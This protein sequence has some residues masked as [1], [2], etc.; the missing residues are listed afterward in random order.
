[1]YGITLC[2]LMAGDLIF[3]IVLE[4]FVMDQNLFMNLIQILE[5]YGIL[6]IMKNYYR[7]ILEDI[8]PNDIYFRLQ[9]VDE[10]FA[11]ALDETDSELLN[12]MIDKT[13]RLFCCTNLLVFVRS[14]YLIHTHEWET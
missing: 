3:H 9:P 7:A 2:P 11:V 5:I 12:I 8:L 4:E 1:M 14:L 6:Q 10:A 13:N